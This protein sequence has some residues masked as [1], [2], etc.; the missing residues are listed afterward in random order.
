MTVAVTGSSGFIGRHLTSMLAEKPEIK[1]IP[2][3][4]TLGLD[5]TDAAVLEQIGSF[6]V[7]IHL[8]GLLSVSESFSRPADFYRTNFLLTLNALELCRRN[9][10]RLVYISTYVYG[11]PDYLPTDENHPVRSYNPYT[12]SKI[13]GEQLCR[14]YHQDFNVP[15]MIVRPFNI[16]GPGQSSAL[17]IGSILAQIKSGTGTVRLHAPHPRRDYVYVDDLCSALL[18]AARY[19]ASDWEILN[20]ASGV[21]YSVEEIANFL[22]SLLPDQNLRI[23]YDNADSCST[24]LSEVRGSYAKINSLLNWSPVTDIRTGLSL[25]VAAELGS[26]TQRNS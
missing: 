22:L 5:L 20:V 24:G 26:G 21:S 2:I 14:A 12:Q 6:D 15:C 10:A 19:Q 8:A 11:M 4:Q 17:L 25:T 3:D 7:L 1:V 13:M 16:Y 9:K 18:M 23:V